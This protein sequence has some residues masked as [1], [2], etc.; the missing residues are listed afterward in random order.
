MI[1]GLLILN[2]SYV[3]TRD[4]WWP[5]D[6]D[7][8]GGYNVYRAFDAPENW[9]KLNA[10]PLPVHYYR[11]QTVL[12]MVTYDVQAS[13]WVSQGTL[14]QWIIRLPDIPYSSV[15]KG[16]A[17]VSNTT[18]DVAVYL[19]GVAYRPVRL[20]ALDREVWLQIDNTLAEGGA[21]SDTPALPDLTTVQKFQVQYFR[22][23]NFVDI[24]TT[25][26]RTFYTVV[27][28]DEQNRELHEPGCPGSE[29]VDSLQVDKMDYMQ[30]EMV[31][32]NG[33][34]FEQVG[35]PAWLMRR[36][37]R[38]KICGCTTTGTGEPR[39][40]CPS[41]FEIGIV[42][43]YYGPY[44]MLYIDPDVAATRELDEGGTK[45]TREA[46]SYLGP[47]PIVQDGDLIV[48]KNGE[49]LIIRGVTQKQPRGV[50]LQ[51]EFNADL[52]PFGDT[53][54]LIPVVQDKYPP[55]IFDPEDTKGYLDIRTGI[56]TGQPELGTEPVSQMEN[57][58]DSVQWENKDK[59]VGRTITF[60]RI[61]GSPQ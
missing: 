16:R 24:W 17:V 39:T 51:Q 59:Q 44:E 19:D 21:V 9:C 18:Q 47:T 60:N 14:G 38:G 6:D 10:H 27:P 42:G 20:N 36:K 61:K 1:R 48:R 49:R 23:E 29:Y 7:A 32:R 11:D 57:I 4:L 52:L 30:A 53:R 26:V 33:W 15:V 12:R 34:L 2:S 40:A 13:D 46:R 5:D 55:A 28:C 8:K 56:F 45:V 31:R 54:Y 58:P 43:G 35:E 3:G 41:C 50:L 25:L 22:L 37:T